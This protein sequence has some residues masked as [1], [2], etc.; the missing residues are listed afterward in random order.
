MMHCRWGDLPPGLIVFNSMN[1]QDAGPIFKADSAGH[2]TVVA[3]EETDERL[4]RL[5]ADHN[6]SLLIDYILA[7]TALAAN[8]LREIAPGKVLTVGALGSPHRHP[9]IN[10]RFGFEHAVTTQLHAWSKPAQEAMPMLRELITR[11]F[12]GEN[13]SRETIPA[14]SRIAQTLKNI[15]AKNQYPT[16]FNLIQAWENR[17]SQWKSDPIHEDRFNTAL[18]ENVEALASHPVKRLDWNM[19]ALMPEAI[20]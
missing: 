4:I 13:V 12:A 2:I 7:P 5:D 8:P 1:A 10:D 16:P 19:W 18:A 20:N 3:V 14:P 11:E 17:K 6:S 9:I 15:H